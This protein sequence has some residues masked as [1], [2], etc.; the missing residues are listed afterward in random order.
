MN[1]DTHTSVGFVANVATTMLVDKNKCV[2][3]IWKL[4]LF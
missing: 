1:I 3:L 4:N 2:S